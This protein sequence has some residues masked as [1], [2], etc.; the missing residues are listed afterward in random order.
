[1]T[2]ALLLAAALLGTA[3]SAAGLE[4]DVT[5]GPD[6]K[7][8]LDLA[9]PAAKGFP[10]VLFIHGGSLTSGDKGDEE[11][12][13]VC[14]PFPGAG[15][16]CA[17]VNYRLAPAHAWPAPAEDVAAA[18]NWVRTNIA[19]RGGDP[20]RLILFGHSSGATLVAAVGADERYLAR[21]GLKPRDLRGVVPMGSIMWDVELEEALQ[22]LGRARVEDAFRK[23]SD[24]QV[25]GTLDTYLDHWPMRHIRAG[26]PPFLF[27]IAEEEQE[28]PPVLKTN[29][30]FAEDARAA[31]NWAE[32]KVLPNRTHGSAIRNLSKAGDPVFAIVRDFVRLFGGGAP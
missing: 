19:A 30:K 25:Y 5:Y 12:R 13:N 18:V 2:L 3:G 1:M 17:N 22:R 27:L 8:R 14:A 32:Y 29:K 24:S 31:G 10:T 28:H 21:Y 9:V 26:L 15:I 11:Y 20:R 7:Q 4:R 16:A 23:D 6:P